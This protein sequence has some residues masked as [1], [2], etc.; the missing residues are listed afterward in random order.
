MK[1]IL[2]FFVDG[3]WESSTDYPDT[4]TEKRAKA[5]VRKEKGRVDYRITP[6]VPK[7]T[8]SRLAIAKGY[9][10]EI[11]KLQKEREKLYAKALKELKIADTHW[12]WDWFFN[13]QQGQGVFT[14]EVLGK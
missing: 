9:Q 2:E 5:I 14:T 7:R 11:A 4:Y 1:Y 10:R 8:K 13:D 12:A 3:H 6:V